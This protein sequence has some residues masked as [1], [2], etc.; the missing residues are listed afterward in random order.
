MTHES[1]EGENL[2][3]VAETFCITIK[4]KHCFLIKMFKIFCYFRHSFAFKQ[5][6]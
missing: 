2:I 4:K 1:E 5:Y 3:S 6:V